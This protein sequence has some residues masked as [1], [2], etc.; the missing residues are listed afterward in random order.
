M[1]GL[2]SLCNVPVLKKLSLFINK[3]RN[4]YKSSDIVFDCLLVISI[5]VFFFI[6]ASMS[7]TV[8]LFY[9]ITVNVFKVNI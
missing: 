6:D 1:I 5:I 8:D 7:I 3:L 4:I 9:G 2:L